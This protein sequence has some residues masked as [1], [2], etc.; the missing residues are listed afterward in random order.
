M[1]NF[2]ER[3]SSLGQTAPAKMGFGASAARAKNPVM[4]V[5]GRVGKGVK[6]SDAVDLLLRDSGTGSKEDG[7]D[8]GLVVDGNTAIDAEALEKDGCHFLLIS[9][10]DAPAEVLLAEELGLGIQVTDGLPEHRIR[11]IEDGPF[12]FLLYKPDAV[13][14]PLTVGSV[15]KLQDLISSFSKHIFLE[16]PADAKMPGKKDLEVLKNLPISAIVVDLGKAK[17]AD[18]SK[19]KD[20]IGEL[21]PR[22]PSNKGERSPMVPFAGRGAPEEVETGGDEGFDDD[23]WED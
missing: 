2:S 9:S 4:L 5:I 6:D 22:K 18:A 10:E 7:P 11:A 3:L 16:L 19:M 23:D 20:A 1:S 12:N 15:L 17:P 8:W 14:W 13:S 21:E